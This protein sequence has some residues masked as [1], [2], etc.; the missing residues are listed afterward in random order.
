MGEPPPAPPPAARFV[1]AGS[2][3]ARDTRTGLEWTRHDHDRALAWQPAS[4][5]C[6]T[7]VLEGRTD[8]RLPEIGELK[9]LY[10]E[11]IERPCGDRTCRVDALIELTGPYVWS[12][13]R[14][15]S[16]RRFYIDFHFGTTLAPNLKPSLLRQVLCVR[17][18]TP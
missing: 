5:Y 10:D 12:A 17:P 6:E 16:P 7:L 11:R 3:V 15:G 8:W 9:A 2:G 4:H 14:S 1:A 13:T 18:A